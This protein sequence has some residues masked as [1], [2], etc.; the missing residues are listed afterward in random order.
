[1]GYVTEHVGA[2]PKERDEVDM[3]IIQDFLDRKGE[4]I[5][6][7]DEVGG[8]PKYQSTFRKLDIPEDNIEAWLLS[9]AAAL[10]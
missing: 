6:S 3:R 2:R 10:E 8:Y 1:M 7:Q 5:D 9:L 4:I